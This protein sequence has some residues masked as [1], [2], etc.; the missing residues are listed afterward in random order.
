VP[1]PLPPEPLE[2]PLPPLP[3]EQLPQPKEVTSLTQVLSQSV[4]QQ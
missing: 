1:P 4:E 2:P 3:P